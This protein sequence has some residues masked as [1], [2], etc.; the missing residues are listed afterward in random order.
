MAQAV[1]I[2]LGTQQ[3]DNLCGAFCAAR[4]L[5]GLGI[6]ELAGEPLDEDLVALRA[7]NTLPL[8]PSGPYVPAGAEPYVDYR[9]ELRRVPAEEAGT[10]ADALAD[11]IASA[12]LRAIPLTGS[13]RPEAVERLL[14]CATRAGARLL[15]NVRTGGFWG[16]RPPIESLLAQLRGVEVEGPPA[17]WDVGHWCEL[18]LLVR[19]PGGALVVVHDTYPS[20]GWDGRHLQP[21]AAVAAALNRGDGREGGVLAVAA[22]ENAQPIEALADGLGVERRYWDNGTRR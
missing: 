8:D 10:T 13:W 20:L 21:P 2:R 9:Y 12:G 15:A 16:S 7:G 11:V 3:K 19:G 4:I 14:E 18:E 6:D 1:E 5:L 17:E 22:R